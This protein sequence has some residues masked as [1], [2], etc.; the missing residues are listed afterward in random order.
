LGL[1]RNVEYR[2]S[3]NMVKTENSGYYDPNGSYRTTNNTATNNET[4]TN[5]IG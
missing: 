3:L 2:S 1:V 5:S 4:K